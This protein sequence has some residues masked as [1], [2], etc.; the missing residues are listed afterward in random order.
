MKSVLCAVMLILLSAIPPAAS[1]VVY[2]VDTVPELRAA[3]GAV[4]GTIGAANEI[5]I[6]IGTYDVAAGASGV[7]SL[8]LTLASAP[9]QITG[10]WNDGCSS[11]NF[12][13]E[14]TI[15]DGNDAVR[16]MSVTALATMGAE[17]L[18]DGI[19]FRNGRSTSG[20]F[21]TCLSVQTDLDSDA[22]IRLDRNSFRGC[23]GISSAV[24]PA[25]N[26]AARSSTVDIR[27]SVFTDNVGTLGAVVLSTLGSGNIRFNGNTVA[28]NPGNTVGGPAGVQ[29]SSIG[30]S[31]T[32]LLTGNILYANGDAGSIDLFVGL[33]DVVFANSNVIGQLGGDLEDLV[34]TQ[35]LSGDPGFQAPTDLRLRPNSI[36][37]NS[38]N[39]GGVGGHPTRDVFGDP[40]IQGARIDRGALE[41]SELFADGFE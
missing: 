20:A 36:A 28:Y 40:R 15:L 12:I 25:L 5:R 13:A 19:S 11:R 7:F 23:S 30:S 33:D 1:A 3:V 4:T 14:A 8:S 37:R 34:Q 38:G 17:L 35:G 26:V 6:E 24:G 32:L 9:L 2:C 27:S 16:I 21:A 31:N 18:I 22:T 10:G 39:N 41:F 29:T